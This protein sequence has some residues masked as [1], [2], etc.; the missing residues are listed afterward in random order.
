[1]Y[2]IIIIIIRR[3]LISI[4]MYVIFLTINLDHEFWSIQDTDWALKHGVSRILSC[5]K[6]AWIVCK[7]VT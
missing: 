5:R 7:D 2:I 4:Y 1:M 3:N 6:Q